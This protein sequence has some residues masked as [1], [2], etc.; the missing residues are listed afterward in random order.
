[1][2]S[3]PTRKRRKPNLVALFAYTVEAYA[4]ADDQSPAGI[5]EVLAHSEDEALKLACRDPA[6]ADYHR[7]IAKRRD[8]VGVIGFTAVEHSR[9]DGK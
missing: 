6:A 1:M 3:K 7:L 2:A 5:F 8:S 9:A 4:H